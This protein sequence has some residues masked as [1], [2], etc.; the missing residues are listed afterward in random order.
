MKQLLPRLSATLAIA[1]VLAAAG[2]H[3][4]SPQAAPPE[5]GRWITENGN[6]EVDIASCGAA[7]CGTIV[8][9]ISDR[10][11][12]GPG[13]QAPAM[14][15]PASSPLGKKILIDLHPV[16]TGGFQGHIYNRADNKTYNSLMALAGPDQLKLTIYKDTP[17]KGIVQ[18]WQRADNAK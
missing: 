10:M 3:A 14:A 13:S 4:Q 15:V 7:L 9:V 12:S 18:I 2:A 1:L 11:M 17:A 8:R 16:A 6:L 5:A